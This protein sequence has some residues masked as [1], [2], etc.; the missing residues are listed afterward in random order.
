VV[1]H[2]GKELSYLN[3]FDADAAWR[4]VH[5][6]AGS[7][8]D[9]RAVA[10]IKHANPCGA[11]VHPDLVTAYQLA[12]EADPQSAFGGIV[13]IGGP[14]TPAVAE[15][16][17]AGPQADLIIAPSY[18]EAALVQLTAK[19]KATRLL[20]A[21]APEPLVRQFRGLGASMLVQ[22]ADRFLVP[23]ASWEV[24]TK[25][26]PTE[27]QWRDLTLAWTVCAR[28]TS[29]AIAIVT[30]GQAVGVAGPPAERR[31]ATPSSPSPTASW[32]W[33]RPGWPR[34]SNPGAPSGTPKWSPPPTRPGSPWSWPV[35]SA[36]SGTDARPGP[37]VGVGPP[38]PRPYWGHEATEMTATVLDGELLAARI[39]A[40]V[41]DRVAR[42]RSV[43]I[44]PGLGTILVGDDGPSARYVAM[45]HE[46]C[47]EVGIH[48]AHE[49]LP[50]DVSQ[51]ELES[52]VARFNADPAIHAYLVQLP[53]PEG[54]DEEAVLMAVDPDKDVDGL[55]PVNLGRLVMGAPGPLPCTPAGIV[56]LLAANQVPVEGQHVVIIGRGLTIGRP[57]SLLLAMRRPGCNAA[58]TV[59]HTGV[60]DLAHLVRQGDVVVAAAGRAGLVTPD[61]VK[62]G[63]A[64]VGAGTSWEGRKLLSD[65]D[66]SVAEV[67]GWITPRLGGVG[68]MTRA[69]LLRNTVRAAERSA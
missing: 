45:K 17:A 4:L 24:A 55:H 46:D 56:E 63:A 59:V 9:D 2:G 44:A 47:A 67:A 29:N 69:M 1:Q 20:S 62:P 66:E 51:E 11:A 3:I 54:L 49:H 61:M 25:A 30:G 28:T 15:A 48:S 22:D 5:E 33:P 52:V 38:G 27:A 68:P 64:V 23:P 6:L 41:T 58:V 40:E 16:I 65:V 34:W 39:R 26:Q 32:S 19:R 13:A 53:L 18:D 42:L 12:L 14:V 43:G 57:L 60:K 21:P 31:P 37:W 50:A 7:A 35:A 36:T 10:I 8:G